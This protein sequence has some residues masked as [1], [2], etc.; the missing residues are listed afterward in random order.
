VDQVPEDVPVGLHLCYGDYGH[1]HFKQPES[2][3][4]QVRVLDAVIAAAGR[5]VSFASFTVPQDQRA[6]S[7]FA[8]L[9]GLT[10]DPGTEL[11]FG[12]VPYHP[13]AQAPG[14]TDDQIWLIDAALADSPGGSRDWGISTECGMGRVDRADIPALLNLH[15]E[16]ITA[17]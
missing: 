10:A 16:I 4:L 3:E 14:T 9:S 13:A 6:E 8:P 15:R 1:Q 7:Y 5:T 17:D 12:L 2:L 11:N